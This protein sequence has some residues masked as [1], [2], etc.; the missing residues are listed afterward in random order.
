MKET[1]FNIQ[2]KQRKQHIKNPQTHI[3]ILVSDM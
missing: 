1:I 3:E 2:N